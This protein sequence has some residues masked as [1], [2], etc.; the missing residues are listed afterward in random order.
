MAHR[1]AQ[2]AYGDLAERRQKQ[3]AKYDN[4][5]EKIHV[6][7][8][9]KNTGGKKSGT[10]Q[11]WLKSGEVLCKLMNTLQPNTIK[12]INNSPLAFKQMENIS[13]FLAVLPAFGV[14]PE[15][16]FQTADLFEGVN[17]AAVQVCI[18][19]IRRVADLKAK[20][21]KVE[22]QAP[23]RSQVDT[24]AKKPAGMAPP[25]VGKV[26]DGSGTV[27]QKYTDKRDDATYGDLAERV[28]RMNAK[29]NPEL[30]KEVRAWIEAKTGQKLGSDFHAALRDGQV[31]CKLANAL[32][33]GSVA[34]INSGNLAFKQMENINN[35]IEAARNIGVRPA[36]LFQTVDLY[37]ANNMTQVL[38]TLDNVKRLTA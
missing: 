20:G 1:G 4:D 12:K 6:E 24:G 26:N 30:E 14:R 37:E 28:E 15:D 32:R 35:F 10:F 11:E 5:V 27:V 22:A 3:D 33:P 34:K 9:E 21:V 25:P 31:L 29:Y 16:T 2:G 19:N 23:T 38:T 13:A 36:D 17:M 7:F 18:E 8:I